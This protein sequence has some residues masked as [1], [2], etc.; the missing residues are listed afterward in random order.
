MFVECKAPCEAVEGCDCFCD[1]ELDHPG[2]HVSFRTKQHNWGT[3]VSEV[4]TRADLRVQKNKIRKGTLKET[5]RKG[6]PVVPM[7]QIHCGALSLTRLICYQQHGHQG[8]HASL[9]ANDTVVRWPSSLGSP[10]PIAR[11]NDPINSHVAAEQIEPTR[12]SKRAAVLDY[13]RQHMDDWVDAP[14]LATQDVGGFGGTRRMRELRQM[15]WNIETRQK[16]NSPNTWQHRLVSDLRQP[17][18]VDA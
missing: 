4:P 2:V 9:D 18:D 5:E 15:G 11:T 17:S 13:L 1:R 3:P 14:G 10:P 7:D 16:P 12:G 6:P 8:D